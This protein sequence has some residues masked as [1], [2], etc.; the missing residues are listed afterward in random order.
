MDTEYKVNPPTQDG[1]ASKKSHSKLIKWIIII[2]I[3]LIIGYWSYNNLDGDAILLLIPGLIFLSFCFYILYM[4]MRPKPNLNVYIPEII[5]IEGLEIPSQSMTTVIGA[6]IFGKLWIFE[7]H[8]EFRGAIA[9][10]EKINYSNIRNVASTGSSRSL[11]VNTSLNGLLH[12]V[13][14]TFPNVKII[15]SLL[16][17][18]KRKNVILSDETITFLTQNTNK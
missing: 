7:D 4:I 10:N 1:T 17:F 8:L 2:F 18:L 9:G 11:S 13:W 6:V 12:T 15:V 3:L 16:L 14:F 5:P